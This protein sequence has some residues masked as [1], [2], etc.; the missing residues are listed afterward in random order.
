[1]GSSWIANTEF[2]PAASAKEDFTKIEDEPL[3]M[4]INPDAAKV[5]GAAD[6][7]RQG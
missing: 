5:E 3:F 7:R 2:F 1:L 6:P 4:R